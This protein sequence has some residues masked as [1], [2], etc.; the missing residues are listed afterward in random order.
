MDFVQRTIERYDTTPHKQQTRGVLIMSENNPF[1]PFANLDPSKFDLT[2]M[3]NEFKLPGVDMEALMETQR[4]NIEAVTQANKV[5]V[6]GMQAV[7][8][9]QA[10]MLSESMA[11]V[12]EAAKEIASAE[13]PQ[14]F[15]SKE[16]ELAREA[17]E[18]ALANM[19]ELAELVGKA[20]SETFE[21][22][23]SRFKETLEELTNL[24]KAKQ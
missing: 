15:T 17:F 1:N 24:I 18:K 23:N 19:R 9:R 6:E 21:V 4:K 11:A 14:E 8:K 7:A 3:M 13:N 22:M 12:S 20:N 10:E 5:A 16:A 2:K